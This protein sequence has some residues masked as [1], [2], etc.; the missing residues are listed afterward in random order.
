MTHAHVH[1]DRG[2]EGGTDTHTAAHGRNVVRL[3]TTQVTRCER[4]DMQLRVLSFRAPILVFATVLPQ[5]RNLA[6]FCARAR[7]RVLC[8]RLTQL[9]PFLLRRRPGADRIR[10]VSCLGWPKN[11][12][13]RGLSF[14]RTC[15]DSGVPSGVPVR[16]ARYSC[17]ELRYRPE[18]LRR[19]RT[20]SQPPRQD[21]A[22]VQVSLPRNV[23]DLLQ[24]D[25]PHTS[26]KHAREHAACEC[27]RE[28][29]I[30]ST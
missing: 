30:T 10:I 6:R 23:T 22:T 16:G 28:G 9:A 11:W 2:R 14:G 4:D 25:A 21:R 12:P 27:M 19:P 29:P 13:K 1:V 17:N 3:C 18:A 26:N 15:T 7:A 24:H 20:R 5:H 8:I